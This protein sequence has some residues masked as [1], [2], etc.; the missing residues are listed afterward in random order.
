ME[1]RA[2]PA[3]LTLLARK[4]FAAERKARPV[5][6]ATGA[7]GFSSG[8]SRTLPLPAAKVI[9]AVLAPIN[10]PSHA[11]SAPCCGTCFGVGGY[12]RREGSWLSRKV[13][14]SKRESG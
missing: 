13:Y 10:K 4:G 2:G 1:I 7:T 8:P 9:Y 14:A 6:I 12:L 3:Q 11:P 5:G